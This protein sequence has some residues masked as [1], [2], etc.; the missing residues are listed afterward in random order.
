MAGVGGYN[1]LVDLGYKKLFRVHHGKNTNLSEE[2][3][4]LMAL[5]AFGVMRKPG[6]QS[7]VES[8]KNPFIII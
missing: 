8:G 5:K 2:R 1:G 3:P 4:I 6:L 7:S